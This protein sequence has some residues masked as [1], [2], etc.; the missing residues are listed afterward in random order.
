MWA[1][2]LSFLS[3]NAKSLSMAVGAMLLTALCLLLWRN[4]RLAANVREAQEALSASRAIRAT[5][6]S[7]LANQRAALADER[8]SFERL[9]AAE[10]AAA[11]QRRNAGDQLVRTI[12][13]EKDRDPSLAQCL[14]M[15]LPDSILLDLPR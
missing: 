15:R 10:R 9:L 6:E 5:L 11:E 3:G 12:T 2:A 8:A 7:D 14:A 4:D 13:V 1:T